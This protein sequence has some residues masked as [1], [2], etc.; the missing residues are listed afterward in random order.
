MKSEVR[1]VVLPRNS[2]PTVIPAVVTGS[3]KFRKPTPYLEIIDDVANMR[4]TSGKSL[5]KDL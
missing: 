2:I 4:E 5:L 3:E 1:S